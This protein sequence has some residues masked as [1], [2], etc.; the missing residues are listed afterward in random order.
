MVVGGAGCGEEGADD[1]EIGSG[2]LVGRD[3]HARAE[4]KAVDGGGEDREIGE[5]VPG[6]RDEAEARPNVGEEVVGGVLRERAEHEPRGRVNRDNARQGEGD[7][8]RRAAVAV[9]GENPDRAQLAC[10]RKRSSASCTGRSLNEKSTVSSSA[11]SSPGAHDGTTKWS[12]APK[13]NVSPA[14]LIRPLPSTTE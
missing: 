6:A 3:V 9:N 13:A 5:D 4:Q 8:P 12:F 11:S 1:E 14:T 7:L 2:P 10:S